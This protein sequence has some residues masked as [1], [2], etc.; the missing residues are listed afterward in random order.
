ME[1]F[2]PNRPYVANIRGKFSR[3]TDRS[4]K[5]ADSERRKSNARLI[6]LIVVMV[7]IVYLFFYSSIFK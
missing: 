7:L 5:S 6:G 3:A 4:F 1:E 2:D